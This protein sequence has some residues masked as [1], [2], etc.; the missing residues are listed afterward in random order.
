[1]LY[2]D[3]LSRLLA[4]PTMMMVGMMVVTAMIKVEEGDDNDYNG[5]DEDN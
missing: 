5:D 4:V 2:N 1:M 3:V